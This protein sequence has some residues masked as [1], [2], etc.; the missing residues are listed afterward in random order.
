MPR[1]RHP[2]PAHCEQESTC[3]VQ[4]GQRSQSQASH[5]KCRFSRQVAH[6][7]HRARSAQCVW[8]GEWQSG[9]A[10]GHS[11][12]MRGAAGDDCRGSNRPDT[13]P[14]TSSCLSTQFCRQPLT[15]VRGTL[16]GA[17]TDVC[18]GHCRQGHARRRRLRQAETAPQHEEQRAGSSLRRRRL[19]WLSSTRARPHN[20]TGEPLTLTSCWCRLMMLSKCGSSFSARW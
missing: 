13:Q 1:R 19:V 18:A 6:L 16:A 2:E 12:A 4:A 8:G 15:R 7:L 10:G 17:H 14:A 3:L 11:A 9:R 20:Q 5:R